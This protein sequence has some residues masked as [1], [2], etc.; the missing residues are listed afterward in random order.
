MSYRS[1]SGLSRIKL[2]AIIAAKHMAANKLV[3]LVRRWSP[4]WFFLVLSGFVSISLVFILPPFQAPDERSHF[5][6]A[7]QLSY[8]HLH[9][10]KFSDRQVGE[11]LPAKYDQ[12][13][14]NYLNLLVDYRQRANLGTVRRDVVDPKNDNS[15]V[16]T[17]FENTAIYPPLAYL[18]Q[19]MGVSIARLFQAPVVIQLYAARLA[20]TITWLLIVFFAIRILPFGKWAAAA[21]TLTPL[22]YLLAASSSND[23]TMFGLCLLFIA[24]ILRIHSSKELVSKNVLVQAAVLALLL[25]LCKQPYSLLVGLLFLIPVRQFGSLRRYLLYCLGSVIGTFLLAALWV[26]YVKGAYIPT[27]SGADTTLQMKFIIDNPFRALAILTDNLFFNKSSDFDIY[28]F[29]GLINWVGIRVPALFVIGNFIIIALLI[30]IRS[31]LERINEIKP[32]GRVVIAILAIG[33]AY[34]I[35]LLIYLSFE[36]PR[37]YKFVGL[38]SRY[39][40]PFIFLL[41]P[42]FSSLQLST[43]KQYFKLLVVCQ[44]GFI[45]IG[46]MTL[47]LFLGRFYSI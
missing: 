18:P 45:F 47:W 17:T 8:G 23:A 26:L 31:P 13:F 6:R 34:S 46:I 20:S 28:D 5:M 3:E 43:T 12:T 4:E 1:K 22:S 39:F 11:L 10:D 19:A 24:L 33:G 9:A 29:T 40:I 14:Q 35:A 32:W 44:A 21:L 27:N 30:L 7:V 42:F 2:L 16:I 38:N 36:S 25:G 15:A 37:T 41:I